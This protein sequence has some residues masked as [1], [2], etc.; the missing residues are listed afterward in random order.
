MCVELEKVVTIYH[1]MFPYND[2]ENAWISKVYKPKSNKKNFLLSI[3]FALSSAVL[4][5][6]IPSIIYFSKL[7]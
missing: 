4:A 5:T 6:T 1:S 3:F 7:N 2:D